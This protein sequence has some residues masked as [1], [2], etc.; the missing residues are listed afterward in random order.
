MVFGSGFFAVALVV[1]VCNV[2]NNIVAGQVNSFFFIHKLGFTVSL[3]V[4][5]GLNQNKKILF[6]DL[7]EI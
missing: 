1:A 2:G 4:Y 6:C 7:D 5:T 3:E